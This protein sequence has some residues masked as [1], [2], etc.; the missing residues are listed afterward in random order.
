MT[1]RHEGRTVIVTGAAA[2]ALT[3]ELVKPAFATLD[4]AGRRSLVGGLEAMEKALS[5]EDGRRG[6]A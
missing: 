4:D 5:S 6:G 1:Q 3:D 2:D